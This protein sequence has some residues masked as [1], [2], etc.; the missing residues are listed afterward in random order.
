[1]GCRSPSFNQ[2]NWQV[3]TN[4]NW[5]L[6]DAIF[7]GAV[8][9]PALD[10]VTLTVGGSGGFL[11]GSQFV[12]EPPAGAFPG[13]A[14]TLTYTPAP[15]LAVFYNGAYQRPGVDYVFSGVTI[16]TAFTTQSGDNIYA[17]YFRA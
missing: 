9:V 12:A 4:Y 17:L 11:L 6:L 13:T 10:V 2:S 3:P 15:L 1:M 7:G 8:Q 16:T 5:S 14:Y